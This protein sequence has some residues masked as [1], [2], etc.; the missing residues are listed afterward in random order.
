[1]HGNL[2]VPVG[3]AR[4]RDQI[5]PALGIARDNYQTPAGLLELL[6]LPDVAR[7]GR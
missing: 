6:D 4:A 3:A 1:M 2:I 7:Q 5:A